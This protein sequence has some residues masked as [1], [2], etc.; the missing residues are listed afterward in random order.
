MKKPVLMLCIFVLFVAGGCSHKKDYSMD[1][2]L[3]NAWAVAIK[4]RDFA[5]Y[6]KYEAYPKT[7]DQFNEIYK[8]YYFSDINVI[9]V[10]SPSDPLKNSNDE[11]YIRKEASISGYV[12]SRKD[13]KRNPFTGKVDLIYPVSGKGVWKITNRIVV[14]SE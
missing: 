11:M 7:V 3:L 12:I 13:Q 8:D 2:G 1:Q 14:R 9:N 5:L 6:S 4:N 10:S